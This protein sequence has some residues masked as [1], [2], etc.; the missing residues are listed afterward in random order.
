MVVFVMLTLQNAHFTSRNGDFSHVAFFSRFEIY[1][2]H[3]LLLEFHTMFILLLRF[4]MRILLFATSRAY[5][6]WIFR[7]SSLG[8]MG[9]LRR[10]G[11]ERQRT[12]TETEPPAKHP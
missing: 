9:G 7:P 4:D 6:L 8:R 12:P 5:A 10:G 3:I 11:R 2:A 1:K